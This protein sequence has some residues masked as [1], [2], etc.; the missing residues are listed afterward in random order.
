MKSDT[1]SIAMS[2]INV[3]TQLLTN[4]THVILPFLVEDAMVISHSGEGHRRVEGDPS[5]WKEPVK[6]SVELF[7]NQKTRL[8]HQIS[9]LERK[10]IFMKISKT[11]KV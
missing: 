3:K 7:A 10:T 9:H 5:S 1:G 2:H 6:K 4:S 8:R 11:L